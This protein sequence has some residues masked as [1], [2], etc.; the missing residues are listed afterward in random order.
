MQDWY[1][2][3][4]SRVIDPF[5]D[6]EFKSAR[7]ARNTKRKILQKEPEKRKRSFATLSKEEIINMIRCYEEE[8]PSGLQKKFYLIVA[9]ELAWRSGEGFQCLVH[10]FKEEKDH[11]GATGRIEY[12]PI[13]SKTTQIGAQK[14]ANSKWLTPNTWRLG[15][16]SCATVKRI[17]K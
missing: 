15:Y 12:N 11:A 14:C 2:N 9:S 1:Y 13:F 4:F 8:T 7:H 16:L 17:T 6:V 5:K 3:K 10:Y